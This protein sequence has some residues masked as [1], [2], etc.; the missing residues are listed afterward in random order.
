MGS[1]QAYCKPWRCKFGFARGSFSAYRIP[2]LKLAGRRLIAGI[3]Q[4]TRQCLTFDIKVTIASTSNDNVGHQFGITRLSLASS[5]R[6]LYNQHLS[7]APFNTTRHFHLS[8]KNE[9]HP[10]MGAT[11]LDGT[12]IAKGIRERLGAEIAEKQRLNPRY[13]PTLKIIQG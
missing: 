2:I 8:P 11:R 7:R 1:W 9:K 3:Q 4:P 10:T 6:P 5:T 12:A 13:K